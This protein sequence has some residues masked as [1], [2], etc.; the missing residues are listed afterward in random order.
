[1]QAPAQAAPTSPTS[2]ASAS[3]PIDPG[4]PAA[5]PAAPDK[6][7]SAT[8]TASAAEGD[9]A[10]GGDAQGLTQAWLMLAQVAEQR[11]DFAAPKAGCRASTTRSAR[12]K[13]RPGA[14]C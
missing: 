12:W 5:G 9:A 7:A 3:A 8:A 2:P 14:R 1:V 13:C 11:G 6:D 10:A 4:A